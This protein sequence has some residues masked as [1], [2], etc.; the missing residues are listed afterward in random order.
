MMPPTFTFA[1]WA[2]GCSMLDYI[3]AII[4][5]FREA[6]DADAISR[7]DDAA[8]RESQRHAFA[9]GQRLFRRALFMFMP[10]FAYAA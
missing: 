9:N 10:L 7:H 8:C 2:V 3:Y 5:D 6:Y 4:A 1:I